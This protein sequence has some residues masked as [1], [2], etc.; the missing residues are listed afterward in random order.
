MAGLFLCTHPL[1]LRYMSSLTVLQTAYGVSPERFTCEKCKFCFS[2]WYPRRHAKLRDNKQAE[3]VQ[4][5]YR[6]LRLLTEEVSCVF[7]QSQLPS[8]CHADLRIKA[9]QLSDANTRTVL[10]AAHFCQSFQ[11]ACRALLRAIV[12]LYITDYPDSSSAG[13]R[14]QT[15]LPPSFA[16]IPS[17]PPVRRTS[18]PP[19]NARS[20]RRASSKS[21]KTR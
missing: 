8:C 10:P 13:Q 12:L 2:R 20:S 1:Q 16:H 14:S 7:R 19:G 15:Q 3:K 6:R 21:Y 17:S 4:I 5:V 11:R 9:M 18:P